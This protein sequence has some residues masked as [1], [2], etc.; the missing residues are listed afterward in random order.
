M[1][2]FCAIV[3]AAAG[4]VAGYVSLLTAGDDNPCPWYIAGGAIAMATL[5][6]SLSGR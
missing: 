3:L 5:L 4:I 2:R 6:L 1:L